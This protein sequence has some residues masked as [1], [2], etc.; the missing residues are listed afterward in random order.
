MPS[1]FLQGQPWNGDFTF[2]VLCDVTLDELLPA[3]SLND[4]AEISLGA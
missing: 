3:S 4:H 1:S 2:L